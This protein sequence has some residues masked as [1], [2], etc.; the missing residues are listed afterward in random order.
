[1][2]V[3]TRAEASALLPGL[4]PNLEA[5]REAKKEVDR[6]RAELERLTPTM[7][8]NG[9]GADA[10]RIENRLAELGATI[11]RRIR[12]ILAQGVLIQDIELGL[13]DFPAEREGRV[14]LLCWRLGE[15]TI[16][17]WHELNG[18]FAG[19]RPL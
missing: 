2:R 19:R 7:R 12:P 4:I 18:G 16:G 5:L 10:A 1:M 6:L 8:G 14:V 13:I 9:S 17:F 15:E 11:Q 3:F